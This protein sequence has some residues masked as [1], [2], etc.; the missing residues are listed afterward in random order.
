MCAGIRNSLLVL[1]TFLYPLS[2]L[3]ERHTG[4]VRAFLYI[5]ERAPAV[6]RD[7]SFANGSSQGSPS[8]WTI[9]RMV[10]FSQRREVESC[11]SKCGKRRLYWRICATEAPHCTGRKEQIRLSLDLRDARAR[12]FS[13]C[14]EKFYRFDEC[15]F[16]RVLLRTLPCRAF[17]SRWINTLSCWNIPKPA[18][19][20]TS[21]EALIGEEPR[22]E[23]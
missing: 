22:A 2:S 21:P 16:H 1:R 5:C 18:N 8:L 15:I 10:F 11:R 13:R 7:R 20:V 12:A 9:L 14:Y 3:K 17:A 6:L 23:S 19:I 4:L